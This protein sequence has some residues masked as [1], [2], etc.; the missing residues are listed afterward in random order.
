[1]RVLEDRLVAPNS[2]FCLLW[3]LLRPR[4]LLLRARDKG[5]DL[6]I[7]LVDFTPILYFNDLPGL[8]QA[9][10][11]LR[12]RQP[13]K[14]VC[15]RFLF[16]TSIFCPLPDSRLRAIWADLPQ[17]A[18]YSLY[19]HFSITFLHI[20]KIGKSLRR[21]DLML[22]LMIDCIALVEALVS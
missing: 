5:V 1:M 22:S 20:S 9:W 12:A 16:A 14:D 7:Y 4:W 19:F 18:A 2:L 13:F 21:L 3:L 15:F 8:A 10:T 17:I 6:V 11:S